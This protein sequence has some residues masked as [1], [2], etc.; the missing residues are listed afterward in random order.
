MTFWPFW[1]C[2][3][4]YSARYSINYYDVQMKIKPDTMKNSAKACHCRM[5]RQTWQEIPL[6]IV[7]KGCSSIRS[8]LCEAP[9]LSDDPRLTIVKPRVRW[10]L[11]PSRMA[12]TP[13]EAECASRLFG[14]RRIAN[15]KV[16]IWK[17]QGQQIHPERAQPLWYCRSLWF[18]FWLSEL[19][20]SGGPLVATLLPE[21][22]VS[23][24]AGWG[25]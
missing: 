25:V 10:V 11:R 6:A 13:P 19:T 22:P 24:L 21:N 4:V 15:S 12:S 16:L 23:N 18:D 2:C 17:G 14:S 7:D 8:C 20:L 3:V 1:M 9:G 5:K